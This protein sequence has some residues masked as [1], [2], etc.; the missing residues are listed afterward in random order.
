[1]LSEKQY[2]QLGHEIVF[3][4]AIINA[5]TSFFSYRRFDSVTQMLLDTRFPS[6][7]TV[8]CNC[9]VLF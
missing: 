5:S 4:L 2:I 7:N 6:V 9:E 1:V 3:A 8:L